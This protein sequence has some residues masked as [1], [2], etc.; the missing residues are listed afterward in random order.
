MLG[1]G[2]G[3]E[4]GGEMTQ[5]MYAHMNIWIKKKEEEKEK[6]EKKICYVPGRDKNLDMGKIVYQI[7]FCGTRDWIQGLV[8]AM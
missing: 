1:E 7:F 5:T 2:G 6:E 8:L 4:Q 3:G